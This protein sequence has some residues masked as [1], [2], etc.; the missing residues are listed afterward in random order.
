MVIAPITEDRALQRLLKCLERARGVVPVSGL[1]GSS[2]PMVAA[3]AAR[4]TRRPLLYVTAHLDEADAALDDLEFFFDGPC[5]LFPAWEM[6]LGGAA[7][8]P[9]AGE[10][11]AERL[12]VC[13]RLHERPNPSRDRKGAVSSPD[14]GPLS[15]GRGSVVGSAS[16]L[17]AAPGQPGGRPPLG[18]A[19]EPLILVAP[20]LA[21]MQPAPSPAQ[22]ADWTLTLH[23][24]Q[25]RELSDVMTW[26]S[27]R[28]Y[29]RL[30]RVE[31]PGD[32]AVRGGILD[33]FVPGESDPLRMEFDDD[34]LDSLRRFDISTQ[35]SQE[36][37]K[38]VSL[39]AAA[40]ATA[41]ASASTPQ[42]VPARSVPKHGPP[43]SEP[44]RVAPAGGAVA[45]NS[46]APTT[47]PDYLPPDA[48]IVLDEPGEIQDFATRFYQRLAEPGSIQPVGKVLDRAARFTQLHLTHLPIDAEPV[49]PEGQ[50]GDPPYAD[51]AA[52]EATEPKT[53]ARP[54]R[55][56]APGAERRRSDATDAFVFDV[57]SL[58]R[59]EGKADEAVGELCRLADD[60]QVYVF[61]DNEGQRQ[62]LSELLSESGRLARD[63][64]VPCQGLGGRTLQT[65]PSPG[66][67]SGPH[68]LL[69][70]LHR[71]FEWV[72]TRTVVVADHEIFRRTPQRTR[73]RRVAASTPLESWLDLQPGDLV[74]HVSH[75]IA[76][77]VGLR[78]L[79]PSRD[80]EGAV[81]AKHE[82][83]DGEEF[84]TLEFADRAHVHVPVSQVDLVQ[85]YIGAGAVRP[86]LSKLSGTR[87][88]KTKQRVE[89]AVGDLASSLLAV[90]A[91][92]E[93]AAGIAFPA[94]TPWQREFEASFVY[95][96]TE[97]QLLVSE[98]IKADLQRTRPADRLLCGD[99]G[100]G[101]TELAMRAAFKVVEYGKQVAVLVPTT[102]LAEQHFQ[103]F[104]ERLAE[105]PFAVRCLSR[106][107]SPAEQK[108]IIE[109]A[110]KGRVDIL[111]GT[112]RLLSKD[113]GFADLGLVVIDEE[114]RFGVEHKDRL[115]QLRHTVDVLTLTATPIPRTLHLA[116]LGIR[117]ISSL[118]TPPLDRRA[119]ATQ[120]RPYDAGLIREAV[121][122]EMSRDGQVYFVHNRVQSIRRMAD[123]LRSIVPEARVLVGHG[124]MKEGELEAVMTAFVRHEADVLAATTIIESGIDI[125]R[126]N[127][128]FINDADRFG[129]ADLHQLRG[130]V[131]RS[132]HRAYCYLL[133][134]RS[135]PVTP[136]AA[137]RLKSIEEFSDLGAGF[138]IAMRDLEI[139]GAGNILGA[140]Q[141]GHIAA[142][143]Y[144]MYCQLLD[145]AVRRLRGEA[146]PIFPRV[147][148][149]LGITGRVPERYIASS[150]A[151][152]DVYR[153]I[154]SCHSLEELRQVEGDLVD[155][156]GRYP[157]VVARLLELAE[158]RIRAAALGIRSIMRLGPDVVFAVQDLRR[159]EPAFATA[160]GSARA[161]DGKTLHWRPPPAYLEPPTLLAMLRKY[162]AVGSD[163]FELRVAR[164]ELKA[165]PGIPT[166][167]GRVR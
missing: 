68:L 34:R 59:F 101:K 84:L 77:F 28:G 118:S 167:R 15:D 105:Y 81:S 150:R 89:E 97:D 38:I 35:R 146:P 121:L 103:T 26:L 120:I 142:V 31:A 44:G 11:H 148:L 25:H 50:V 43:S 37:L 61:C 114:Q 133:L 122:R 12:R 140:E 125:P 144:E 24:G 72:S 10:I 159:L 53:K 4:H 54:A 87:W 128:I 5:Q 153:R 88:S 93:V 113:V 66:C 58:S 165:S 145:R 33:V 164:D 160:P 154:V 91:A 52:L 119:I 20:I 82:G 163:E 48:L 129:L 74:V 158:V 99:V 2:A 29:T 16:L 78:T 115:R 13:A 65:D 45:P 21:L 138:R 67:P 1:W 14:G 131:G 36:P 123:D 83:K 56:L 117:D 62:R 166:T 79:P 124:Q 63:T 132:K 6:G 110:R 75:G 69:G 46:E 130:R 17:A 156:F 8:G 109:D 95:E 112:H 134:P 47:L 126:V 30:E 85:K 106:F 42:R 107:R 80:R 60:R 19:A 57:T 127:T 104:S 116:M 71:G 40:A 141:S 90:Q 70:R 108:R 96:E 64:N 152:I 111:I 32:F 7:E 161:P 39:T 73:L 3:W 18:R 136:K 137:R 155:A 102:V 94:D 23:A 55:R 135:R 22:L 151:R 98:Q 76:R 157:E 92:R 162:L 9:A 41:A 49:E 51:G 100:Y 139:R 86:T 149:E 27:D 147:S 143:G